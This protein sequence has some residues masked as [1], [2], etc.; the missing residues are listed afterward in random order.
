MSIKF[1]IEQITSYN[2][3]DMKPT[4]INRIMSSNEGLNK[5]KSTPED[6]LNV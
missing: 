4:M 2:Y 6:S 5:K 3:K 1:D